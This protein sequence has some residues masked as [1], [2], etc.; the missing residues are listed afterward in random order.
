MTI[1]KRAKNVLLNVKAGLLSIPLLLL[2]VS[3]TAQST[4][5]VK[6]RVLDEKN[7]PVAGASV[8]VKDAKSGVTTDADGHFSI[9]VAARAS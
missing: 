4:L 1:A 6:G 8:T 7:A 5:T 2:C 9:S 3:L